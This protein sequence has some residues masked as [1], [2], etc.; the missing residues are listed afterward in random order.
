MIGRRTVWCISVSIGLLLGGAAAPGVAQPQDLHFEEQERLS[1][2]EAHQ[3]VAVDAH[4]VYAIDNQSIGKY[5]KAS[6]ERVDGWK[7][8]ENGPVRHLNSGVVI[9][10][11]LYCAHSNFPNVP[12]VSSIE[13]WEVDSMEHVGRHAFGLYKGSATW[14]DRRD[15]DW[16]VVFAHYEGE[17]GVE[18]KGP[19]WT[20]LVRF[21]DEWRAKGGW[22]FPSEVIDRFRPYSNSGGAWGPDGRLYVTGHDAAEVY[23]L[24]RPEAGGTLDYVNTIEFPGEGQGIAWD[25]SETGVLYGISRSQRQIVRASLVGRDR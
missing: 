13:M 18:D 16:W 17:G 7:G 10:D 3:A 22:G 8:E 15:G 4:Y 23:L 1:A 14:V 24:E 5:E 2:S 21:D 25:P 11:T 20:A 12:M 6:G 9:D 19:E